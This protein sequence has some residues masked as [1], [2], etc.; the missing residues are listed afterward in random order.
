M[1]TYTQNTHMYKHI[2]RYIYIHIYI[3]NPFSSSLIFVHARY[4]MKPETESVLKYNNDAVQVYSSLL[5]MNIF[6]FPSSCS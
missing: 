3:Y 5:A 6:I 4:L 1:H 2:H